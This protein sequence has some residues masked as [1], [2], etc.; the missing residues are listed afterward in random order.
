MACARRSGNSRPSAVRS[1]TRPPSAQSLFQ[2]RRDIGVWAQ[3]DQQG[4]SRLP[5]ARD[6]KNRGAAEPAMREQQRVAKRGLATGDRGLDRD[7]GQ[8][9]AQHQ[10]L[11][12]KCQ[13]HQTGARGHKPKAEVSGNVIG[14][15]AGAH[16][17][18]RLATRGDN[19]ARRAQRP[20][21]RLNHKSVGLSGHTADRGFQ[22]QLGA[23][24]P[25]QQH[26][27][28]LGRPAIAEQLSLGLLV[29]GYPGPVHQRDKVSRA[30]A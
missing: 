14:N 30:K 9:S 17:R 11:L 10:I 19:H 13:R 6:L 3:I 21:P 23:A 29:P 15:A 4:L 24:H 20:A 16:F 27:D 7:P 18:N 22:S 2:L 25:M 26:V 5:V 8:R 12:G 28:D 1:V